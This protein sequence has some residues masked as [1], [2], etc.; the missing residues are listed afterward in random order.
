[1][2]LHRV[3]AKKSAY[4]DPLADLKYDEV[5]AYVRGLK[6]DDEKFVASEK[7]LWSSLRLKM[8]QFKDLRAVIQL[9]GNWL[10]KQQ[11]GNFGS[12]MEA[13]LVQEMEKL[14]PEQTTKKSR[15][16]VKATESPT[17]VQKPSG[18]TTFA[19]RISRTRKKPGKAGSDGFELNKSIEYRPSK[20]KKESRLSQSSI[21]SSPISTETESKDR[22]KKKKKGRKR[23]DKN[24]RRQT[25]K[26]KRETLGKD[27]EK[28]TIGRPTKR[29]ERM[30]DTQ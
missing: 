21:G 2:S 13:L 1:V 14:F 7:F 18:D 22:P 26:S 24:Q 10:T 4:N 30:K 15:K 28:R 6:M 27:E 5:K 23:Q 19:S 17:K 3:E 16:T 20:K 12:K 11:Q 9:I 25:R 29:I 8:D